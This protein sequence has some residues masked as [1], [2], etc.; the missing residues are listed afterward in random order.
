M[1]KKFDAVCI[2]SSIY[3]ILQGEPLDLS[4]TIRDPE[5]K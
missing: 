4:L 2:G 1:E 5:Q 3:A